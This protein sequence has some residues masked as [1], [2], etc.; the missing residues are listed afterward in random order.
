MSSA[1]RP[2]FFFISRGVLQGPALYAYNDAVFDEEDW[3]GV[4]ML[5]QSVKQH[6]RFKV[7]YF[8]MGFK[9]IFHLTGT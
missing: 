4:R 1:K 7:G 5:S 9:S 2:P 3:K 8:G 6:D